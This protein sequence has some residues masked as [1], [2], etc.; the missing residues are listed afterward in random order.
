MPLE[1]Y[2]TNHGTLGDTDGASSDLRAGD[3][4]GLEK[5]AS[6]VRK[7]NSINVKFTKPSLQA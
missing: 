3:I 4:K 1:S 2:Q 5:D 6:N 7:N